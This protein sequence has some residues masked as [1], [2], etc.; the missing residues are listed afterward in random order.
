M[1]YSPQ[2]SDGF[3]AVELLITILTAAVFTI[4]LYQLFIVAN[5]S[6]TAVK[7]RAIASELAYSYLRKY[8]GIDASPSWF[9]CDTASGSSNTNDLTVNAQAQGQTV[10]S[11]NLSNVA[12]IPGTVSYVVKGVAPYG[13]SGGNAGTPIKVQASVTYGNSNTITHATLVGY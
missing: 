10:A 11:G 5:N 7:Q 6:S 1:R 13:C 9:T 8:S 4:A 3:T 2:S 12:G